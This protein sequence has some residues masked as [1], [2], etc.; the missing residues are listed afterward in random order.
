MKHPKY[1]DILTDLLFEIGGS[2]LIA[3]AV[4]NFAL[5][6]GFPKLPGRLSV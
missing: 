1:T 5:A 2:T 3:V 4:H 6:A